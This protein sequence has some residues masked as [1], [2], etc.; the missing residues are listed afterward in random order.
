VK[1]HIL[2]STR[3]P[4]NRVNYKIKW[5]IFVQAYRPMRFAC[6]IT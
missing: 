5:K 4:E 2:W 6:W 1:T 3:C